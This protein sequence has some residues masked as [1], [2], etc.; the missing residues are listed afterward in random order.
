MAPLDAALGWFP[1]SK[2]MKHLKFLCSRSSICAA[3]RPGLVAPEARD[4]VRPAGGHVGDN[5]SHSETLEGK[6]TH[7]RIYLSDTNQAAFESYSG[8][9]LSGCHMT[10]LRSEF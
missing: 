7:C 5:L 3:V 8:D 6:N 2:R 4:R 1:V 10:R 9:H